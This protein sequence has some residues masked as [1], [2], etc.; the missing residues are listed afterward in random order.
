[1][2]CNGAGTLIDE[3][4]NQVYNIINQRESSGLARKNDKNETMRRLC[5]DANPVDAGL[6]PQS[7]WNEGLVA[8]NGN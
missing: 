6:G 7:H 3:P 1:V 2:T 8:G 4:Q 5:T